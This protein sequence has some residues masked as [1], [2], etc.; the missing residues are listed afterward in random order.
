MPVG[1]PLAW[2]PAGFVHPT[3]VELS[4]GHHLRPISADDVGI[5]YPAVMGSRERL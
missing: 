4:S 3:R 1:D 2:L 5:D